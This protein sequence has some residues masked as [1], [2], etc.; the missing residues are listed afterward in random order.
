MGRKLAPRRRDRDARFPGGALAH[1]AR[2]CRA[3]PATTI[4]PTSPRAYSAPRTGTSTSPRPG[5]RCSSVSALRPGLESL[6]DDPQFN[7]PK[8]R[9]QNRD[10]LNAIM[11]EVTATKSS[12]EWI[13]ILN[14]AGV[15]CGPIYRIDEMFADPQVKHLG[16]AQ[17]VDHPTLGRIEL[18][19]QAV[20]LEPHAVA[21]QDR[22]AR[23]R[24]AH[25]RGAARARLRRRGD[26]APAPGGRRL[27]RRK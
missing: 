9:R 17:A 3:R 25:R 23:A 26:R 18:V 4:R 19:G 14:R 5:R 2:R 7:T 8:A 15:P 10:K 27:R 1:R 16:I 22:D 21:A 24:R 6:V 11:E 13:D 12:A 20:T